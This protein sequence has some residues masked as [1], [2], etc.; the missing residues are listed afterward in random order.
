MPPMDRE[1]Q[2]RRAPRPP[3]LRALHTFSAACPPLGSV[4]ELAD[5]GGWVRRAI[6]GAETLRVL[7]LSSADDVPPP[8]APDGLLD[9]VVRR[10]ASL[11]VLDLAITG[12]RLRRLKDV[13]KCCPML[14]EVCVGVDRRMLVSGQ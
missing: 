8:R 10:H 1:Q 9:H 6:G 13:L 11:R 3:A 5:L 7:R 14:E 2:M 4:R 12:V